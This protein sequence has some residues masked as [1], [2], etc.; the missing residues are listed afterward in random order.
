MFYLFL[1][2][3]DTPR[4]TALILSKIP[5]LPEVLKKEITFVPVKRVDEVFD[6]VLE[7]GTAFEQYKTE[8]KPRK[9]RAP[10]TLPVIRQDADRDSIRCK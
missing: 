8:I 4:H 6:L 5:E 10:K 1:V 2:L 9:K 7:G 3:P